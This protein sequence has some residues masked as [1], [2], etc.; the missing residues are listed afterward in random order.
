MLQIM[1][2]VKCTVLVKLVHPATQLAQDQL[3]EQFQLVP[4]TALAM[5]SNSSLCI[6]T[7][8]GT[9]VRLLVLVLWMKSPLDTLPLYTRM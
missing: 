1:S 2:E 8:L 9:L 5:S 3:C 4:L 6:L 7:S